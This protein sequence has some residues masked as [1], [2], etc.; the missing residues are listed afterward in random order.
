MFPQT[1]EIDFFAA[2]EMFTHVFI[3]VG[4]FKI[5]F[6]LIQKYFK[7]KQNKKY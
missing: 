6:I 3:F 1:L 7:R 4:F 2:V 5:I